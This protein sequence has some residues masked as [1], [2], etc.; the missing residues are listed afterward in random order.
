MSENSIVEE[1][2]VSVVNAETQGA[3]LHA[4]ALAHAKK[5]LDSIVKVFSRTEKGF[6]VGMLKTGKLCRAYV[7]ERMSAPLSHD[8]EIA[9]QNVTAALAP[10]C[11]E[12]LDV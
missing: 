9:I 6:R 8:R 2:N 7:T 12:K 11:T 5:T 10:Y 1:V 4:A 3:E